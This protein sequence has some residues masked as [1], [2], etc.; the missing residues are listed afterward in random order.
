MVL[1]TCLGVE[2]VGNHYT[3]P[4]TDDAVDMTLTPTVEVIG[5][6]LISR[7]HKGIIHRQIPALEYTLS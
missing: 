6:F 2:G 4:S 7:R 1:P 3:V 5:T